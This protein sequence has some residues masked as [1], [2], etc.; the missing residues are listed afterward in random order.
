M[1][2]AAESG[3]AV[4]VFIGEKNG[5]DRGV[6][7]LRCFDGAA[8]GF[9]AAAIDSVG[10]NDQSFAALL[11]GHFLVRG[12]VNGVVEQSA[13]TAAMAVAAVAV[14]PAVLPAWVAASISTIVL[15]GL[16]LYLIFKRKDWL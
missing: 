15:T 2:T 3:V 11:L 16:V 14:T 6:G 7:A 12:E 13:A 8:D 5:K 10:E 9:F 1:S 4:G